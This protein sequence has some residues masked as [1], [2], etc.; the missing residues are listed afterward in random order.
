[1]EVKKYYKKSP[2]KEKR[3]ATAMKIWLKNCISPLPDIE[4]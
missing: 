4:K 2:K 1:M 3:K